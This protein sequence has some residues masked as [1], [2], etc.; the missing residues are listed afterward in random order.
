[1]G[2]SVAPGVSVASGVS[3]GQL[4]SV[5]L[6]VRV[7]SGVSVALGRSV[8]VGDDIGLTVATGDSE[9]DGDGLASIV[10]LGLALGLGIG[11]GL[12]LGLS[13]GATGLGLRVRSAIEGDGFDCEDR[14][15]PTPT[16]ATPVSD[17]AATTTRSTRPNACA[18]TAVG[19]PPLVAMAHASRTARTKAA[20]RPP[21][22]ADPD[23]TTTRGAGS[24][25]TAAITRSSNP[26][27]GRTTWSEA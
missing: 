16:A 13:F 10:G 26:A 14:K 7:A 17:P 9:L 6:G 3:V 18:R 5:G 11:L 19:R 2:I 4:V 12:G 24:V 1:L 25:A 15:L 20:G 21:R 27:L 8:A 23:R 22:V